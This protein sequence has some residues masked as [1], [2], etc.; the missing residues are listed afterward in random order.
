L[1]KKS[2]TPVPEPS[3]LPKHTILRQ[4]QARVGVLENQQKNEHQNTR[5]KIQARDQSLESLKTQLHNIT[6][7]YTAALQSRLSQ[8][9]AVDGLAARVDHLVFSLAQT[10]ELLS[11]AAVE[12]S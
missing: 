11:N 9:V 8:S 7:K 12:L 3:A 1:A 6:A 5:A 4:L 10:Q 2:T